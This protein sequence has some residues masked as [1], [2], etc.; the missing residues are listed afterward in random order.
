[1]TR[2]A[3]AILALLVLTGWTEEEA[4]QRFSGGWQMDDKAH[5]TAG[6]IQL[7]AANRT[8][9]AAAYHLLIKGKIDRI[10]I[11]GE[12]AIVYVGTDPV[13]LYSDPDADAI[14]AKIGDLPVSIRFRRAK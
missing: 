9:T 1:M 2:I 10:E 3:G 14:S 13:V 6:A 11:V 5:G 8:I 7:D 4:L 12:S